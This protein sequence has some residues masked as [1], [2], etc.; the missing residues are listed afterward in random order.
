VK[1]FAKFYNA[2]LVV[3]AAFYTKESQLKY[4]SVGGRTRNHQQN[5]VT[6]LPSRT[7]TEGSQEISRKQSKIKHFRQD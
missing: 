4:T 1:E 7:I 2:G 5:S 6:F 3:T